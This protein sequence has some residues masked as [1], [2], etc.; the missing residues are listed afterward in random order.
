M[1][2]EL[3]PYI[4]AGIRDNAERDRIQTKEHPELMEK[5]TR[6]ASPSPAPS[7]TEGERVCVCVYVRVCV[8]VCMCMYCVSY[9]CHMC[10]CVCCVSCLYYI[11][12]FDCTLLKSV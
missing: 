9:L 12:L 2:G 8:C 5:L 6:S 4:V 3:Q 1:F 11:Y 10:T 7:P